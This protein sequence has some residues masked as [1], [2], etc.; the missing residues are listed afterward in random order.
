[1]KIPEFFSKVYPQK[2]YLELGIRD[3][4]KFAEPRATFN[5]DKLIQSEVVC[6]AL[7]ISIEGDIIKPFRANSKENILSLKIKLS[8]T[9]N[10]FYT[11]F[12]VETLESSWR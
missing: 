1:M 5:K 10:N 9:K 6:E 8:N 2:E 11:L 7:Q 3:W 12:L 4:T